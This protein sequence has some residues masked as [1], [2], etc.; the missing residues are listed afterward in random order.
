M[1]SFYVKCR[2]QEVDAAELALRLKRVFIGYPAWRKGKIWNKHNV[3][4]SLMDISVPDSLWQ[5]DQLAVRDSFKRQVS[6]NRKFA[7]SVGKG[8]FVV[9]PRPGDGVCHIGRI[10]GKFELIDN[11]CWADE[12]LELRRKKGLIVGSERSHIG[13]VIQT[14]PVEEFRT[15]AFPLVPSWIRYRLLSRN[16]LGWINNR[17]DNA[18]KATDVLR[19]MY[20]GTHEI[21]L[22]QTDSIDEIESRLLDWTTPTSFE[23]LVCALLQCEFPNVRWVHTGGSGDGGTD[24]IAIDREGRVVSALQ[25]K[26]KMAGTPWNLGEE[27]ASQ[28]QKKWEITPR[29]YVASLYHNAIKEKSRGDVTFLGRKYIAKLLLKY[30]EKCPMAVTLGIV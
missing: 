18:R 6:M 16:T 23:H 20:D 26:W 4:D 22:T 28:L 19:Q 24:G 9:I 2:P 21:S 15:V 17:P 1:R 27:L 14:W 12:Y 13:D 30:K 29:V 7:Q 25:C 11:P 3:C 5:K 10:S 8:S